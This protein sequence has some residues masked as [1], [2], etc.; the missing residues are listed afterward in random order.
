MGLLLLLPSGITEVNP[1]FVTV[2]SYITG[3]TLHVEGCASGL[4]LLF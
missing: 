2:A 4:V 3:A 1:P